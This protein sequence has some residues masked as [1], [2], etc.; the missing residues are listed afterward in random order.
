MGEVASARTERELA[1]L[2]R[3]IERDVDLLKQRAR[4]D[5]DPRNLVRR[6]PL[7]ILGSLGSLAVAAV[8]G[9]VRRSRGDR[10]ATAQADVLIERFGGRIDKLRGKARKTFRDQLRKEMREVGGA[11][12]RDA[13]WGAVAAALTALA[14]TVAQRSAQ[15]LLGD[16]RTSD[17]ELGRPR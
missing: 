14:T 9:L 11:G 2:R 13:L 17:E 7:P 6:R 15:R 10:N 5:I 8:V 3:A 1:D 4:E 12:P 16:E